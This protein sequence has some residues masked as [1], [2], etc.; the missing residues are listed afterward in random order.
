MENIEFLKSKLAKLKKEKERLELSGGNPVQL[1]E[2]ICKIKE[3]EEK[4]KKLE[5]PFLRKISQKK[6]RGMER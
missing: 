2:I 6:D 1:E 4:I 3:I 5:N